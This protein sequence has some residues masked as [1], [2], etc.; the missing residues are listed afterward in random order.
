VVIAT[1]SRP[2]APRG[3]TLDDPRMHDSDSVLGLEQV[4]RTLVV[5]GGGVIGCEYACIFASLG[6]KVTL[7]DRRERLLR[8]MDRELTDALCY[9]MRGADITLRLGEN[10]EKVGVDGQGR[11]EVNLSSGKVVV[12][13]RLLCAMGRAANVEGL[14]LDTL[15]LALAKSGLLE[16]NA[17]F[18]THLHPHI[19]AVG[20][21]IGFPSLA[22]TAMEQGRL[23]SCHA[24]KE[25]SSAFPTS[26][27]YGIYTIPEMSYVGA[28][29]EELTERKVPY[30][31]GRAEYS[32]T[33]R[34]QILGDHG[35]MLKLLF[36]RG[37][38]EL[39]GAHIIGESATE[40]IHIGQAVIAHG[41][42]VDYFK[43]QVFNYPTLAEAYKVAALNGLNRL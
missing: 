26:F 9:Q 3:L 37:T 41:G 22:S 18:Q 34:G 29:E 38:H 33:A 5:L 40:L 13:E 16:V 35:G 2:V 8:F 30:E 31:V 21:V 42:K 19:Y 6:T 39:L 10:P 11:V 27:P 15:G 14:G 28:T 36:H 23:A 12:A 4:P 17:F 25:A 1:G 32:E 24:F 7:V 20:D 43:D